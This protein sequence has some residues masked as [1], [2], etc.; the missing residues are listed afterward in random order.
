ISNMPMAAHP[1][2][3]HLSQFQVLNRQPMANI[4]GYT[5]TWEDSFGKRGRVVPLLPGCTENTFCKD[6]GPP[7]SYLK[8]NDDGAVGGNPAFSP[9]FKDPDTGEESDV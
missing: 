7:L 4:A 6:Y 8:P 3:I 5:K 2:H 9:Y 1:V